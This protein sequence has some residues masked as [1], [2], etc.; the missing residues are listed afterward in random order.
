MA[1]YI[2]PADTNPLLTIGPHSK[3]ALLHHRCPPPVSAQSS[4]IISSNTACRQSVDY[5]ITHL[6]EKLP[7]W[8]GESPLTS[9]VSR[10]SEDVGKTKGYY[11]INRAL[12]KIFV[13]PNLCFCDSRLRAAVYFIYFSFLFPFGAGII[14]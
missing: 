11:V 10:G 12:H 5:P 2:G 13:A 8:Q 7:T 9:V 1:S 6:P 14:F 4:R 3:V